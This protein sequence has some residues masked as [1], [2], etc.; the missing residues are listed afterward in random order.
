MSESE[1]GISLV[2]DDAFFRIQRRIGL[3]PSQGPGVVRRATFFA[4]LA[5]L[6]IVVWAGYT[7]RALSGMADEPLR[8]HFGIHV[9]FLIAVPLFILEEEVLHGNGE[10]HTL[11]SYFRP[12]SG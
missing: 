1:L 7:G 10:A 12:R 11:F 5:W 2:R 9:R 6:P 4:P 8:Q 3:I